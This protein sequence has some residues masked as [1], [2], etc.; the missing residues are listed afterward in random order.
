MAVNSNV[1]I[2]KMPGPNV[3][4]PASGTYGEKAALD[5]LQQSLPQSDPAG[6]VMGGGAADQ[7]TPSMPGSVPARSAGRSAGLPAG[8]L[9]PSDRPDEPIG[10]MPVGPVD[11]YA[12]AVGAQQRRLALLDQLANHP[13]A[14]PELREW[15]SIV[16]ERLIAR[17]R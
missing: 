5:R 11:P 17:A 16:R 13:E 9:R 3:N 14:S 2:N 6:P 15:A 1:D 4:R 8:L 10:Q 7:P 12:G